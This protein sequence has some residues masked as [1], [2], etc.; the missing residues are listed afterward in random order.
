MIQP[1]L[2][3]MDLFLNTHIQPWT[4]VGF[5]LLIYI[6]I[7]APFLTEN[8]TTSIISMKMVQRDLLLVDIYRR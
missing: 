5:I 1:Q 7:S 4:G 6:H 2:S 3:G 8:H